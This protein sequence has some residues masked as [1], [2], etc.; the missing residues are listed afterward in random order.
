MWPA[1]AC[2]S[3]AH[4]LVPAIADTQVRG[5]GPEELLTD[6]LYGS[7]EN[8]RV[9]AAAEVELVAP[10]SKGGE[11][12]PLSGFN[13]MRPET[14]QPALRGT[15]PRVASPKRTQITAPCLTWNAVKPVRGSRNAR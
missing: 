14:S 9:A 3:D 13:S 1:P 7:D 2:E 8:H 5:L 6:T 15:P 4:A 12:K 11:K 10:T